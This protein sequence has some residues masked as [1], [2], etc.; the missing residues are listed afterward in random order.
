MTNNKIERLTLVSIVDRIFGMYYGCTYGDT[1]QNAMIAQNIIIKYFEEL[2]NQDAI[3][4][5][6]SFSNGV[7]DSKHDVITFLKLAFQKDQRLFLSVKHISDSLNVKRPEYESIKTPV[8]ASGAK[9]VA[10]GGSCKNSTII[11]GN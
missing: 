5:I 3:E 11:T 8:F 9:S 4:S 7:N 2:D 1:Y 10:I 6:K